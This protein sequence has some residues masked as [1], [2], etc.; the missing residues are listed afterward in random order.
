MTIPSNYEINVAT[1][2]EHNAKYGRHYCRIELGE[3]SKEKAI[4]KFQFIKESF[5][6]DWNLTLYEIT[7]YG[8]EITI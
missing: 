8:N 1:P 6:D 7:C 5:P 2:S 3:C 4:E